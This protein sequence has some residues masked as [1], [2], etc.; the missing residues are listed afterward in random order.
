[1]SLFIIE[2]SGHNRKRERINCNFFLFG[3]FLLLNSYSPSGEAAESCCWQGVPLSFLT[4][5]VCSAFPLAAQGVARILSIQL[6]SNQVHLSQR[7]NRPQMETE[8]FRLYSGTPTS[9]APP[10]LHW[11]V[12][13]KYII[14]NVLYLIVSAITVSYCAVEENKYYTIEWV[15]YLNLLE[16]TSA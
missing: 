10:S 6:N 8:T 14:H 7:Q 4:P 2:D 3:C 9:A 15:P 16:E 1:M 12:L 13:L 11:I 5:L